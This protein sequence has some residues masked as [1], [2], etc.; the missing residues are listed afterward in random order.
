MKFFVFLAA[1]VSG[2]SAGAFEGPQFSKGGFGL[3][4]QYGPGF[5]N[6]DQSKL[7][8]A[9]NA[10]E[11]SAFVSDLKNTHTVSVR[12]AYTILG[13]ASIGAE[14]T[15]TGWDITTLGRGGAGFAIGS[16]TWHPLELV[17]MNKDKRPLPI[18]VGLV[19]GIGYGIAGQRRGM[20]GLLFEGAIDVDF[21]FARYIAVG[22]FGRGI[23]FN[24]NNLYLDF[25]NRAVPGNT[26]PLGNVGSVGSF[27][28]F[29]ISVTLR[30]GD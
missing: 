30:A 10:S 16:A 12:A 18:D 24:W 22:L 6:I 4:V 23:F 13:H 1:I 20:D 2:F 21:F 29:G 5:W 28:T 25:E 14:L 15:G 17:F 19:F 27:F 9:T 3:T 26:L 7:A 8:A 11:A